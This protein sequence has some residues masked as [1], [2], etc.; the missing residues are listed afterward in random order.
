MMIGLFKALFKTGY[1]A[2]RDK[3]RFGSRIPGL[4]SFIMLLNLFLLVHQ[5]EK[6]IQAISTVVFSLNVYYF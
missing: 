4:S 5:G 1:V 6:T 2:S 3:T